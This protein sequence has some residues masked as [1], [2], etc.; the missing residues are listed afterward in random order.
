[1]TPR[2]LGELADKYWQTKEA[3]LIADKA[4]QDLKEAES[5]IFAKLISEMREE[6]ISVIGGQNVSLKL[7]I[8]D[9]PV[10]TDWTT[11]YEHLKTEDDL[12]LLQRRLSASAIKERWADGQQVPGVGTFPVYK[13]SKSKV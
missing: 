5:A 6:N 2:E 13:L 3:R 11:F 8:S 12:S 10:I 9:E 1:M 4:A 7:Q